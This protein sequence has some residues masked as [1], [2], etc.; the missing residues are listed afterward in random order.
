M[1]ALGANLNAKEMGAC[2]KTTLY[3]D[4]LLHWLYDYLSRVV[5]MFK[6]LTLLDFVCTG[7]QSPLRT[8]C[9]AQSSMMRVIG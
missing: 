7:C 5:K 9:S 4:A 8:F 1:S 3:S 2:C 6:V